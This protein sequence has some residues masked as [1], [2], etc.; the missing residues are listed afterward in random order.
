MGLLVGRERIDDTVDCR[1]GTV[2]V[3]GTHHENT[4]LGSRD[5]DTDRLEVTHFADQDHVGVLA[6]G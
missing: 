1:R 6:Q 5:C 3:Q 2:G 4:H